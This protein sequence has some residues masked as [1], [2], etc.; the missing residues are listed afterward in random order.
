MYHRNSKKYILISLAFAALTFVFGWFV[1]VRDIGTDVVGG[2]SGGRVDFPA[3]LQESSADTVPDEI[4]ELPVDWNT[5][6]RVWKELND[7]FVEQPLDQQEL[8]YG[9]LKGLAR[10]TDD[11][12]TA[13]LP[14]EDNKR[15]KDNLNGRYEGIGAEL[16]MRDNQ[17][18]VISPLDGS[19]ALAAGLKAGDKILKVDGEETAEMTLSEAVSKIRGPAGEAVVLNLRRD[20]GEPF[21]LTIVREQITI[22][23]VKWEDKGDGVVY[24]R[25]SRF[26][27]QTSTD[28]DSVVDEI[29]DSQLAALNSVVLDVRSNP[30]GYLQASIH[31][32]AEFLDGQVVVSEQF[33]D[34]RR[35]DFRENRRGRLVGVPVVVLIDEGSASASEI[36][37]GALR[38]Q[39]GFKLVGKKTFG[40]GT[41]Q[42]AIEFE[43]KS[44]LHVTVAYW[45]TPNGAKI[46][47]KGLAPDVEMELNE[48]KFKED[49]V[50]TQ[51]EKA[52]EIAR[53]M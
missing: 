11:P 53:G 38:D 27:E 26:G 42:D 29:L 9:A 12:Y 8:F 4:S 48:E 16:G 25:I 45:L 50:D 10:S 15:V 21:D 19:P 33:G 51:L 43:D 52:L 22:E 1:G 36:L 34:G 32:A 46:D 39:L 37:A 20:G 44:S 41:V 40:K 49:N 5:F 2:I 30:G 14:P 18:T 17:L 31:I 24:I 6:R 3:V 28:W 47:G 7:K 13:F 23:S 35:Q